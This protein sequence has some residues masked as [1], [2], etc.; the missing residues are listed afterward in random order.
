VNGLVTVRAFD[1]VPVFTR[2]MAEKVNGWT[3][4][5]MAQ[6]CC[7]Q[8]LGMRISSLAACSIFLT[9]LAI[10]LQPDR[11]DAGLVGLIL[12]YANM[13]NSSLQGFLTRL[14]DVEI[15][16]NGVER[17]RYFAQ[18]VVREAPYTAEEPSSGR[19]LEVAPPS[20]PSV[21][22]VRFLDVAAKYRPEL[23]RVL[24]GLTMD[25]AASQKVGVC[26]RT[27][28]G[29]STLM[30]LLF[31]ILE[32]DA[33]SIVIDGV[34]IANLGLSQL[35]CAIAMLPQ[36]PT[37][38]S[39][40]IRQNLDPFEQH[41]DAELTAALEKAQLQQTFGR[42]GQ[43]LDSQVGEGGGS[44]S[45]GQR[46]LLCFARA[47]LRGSKLLVMDECTANVDV[48]TDAV[49]QKMVREVFKDCT[50]FTIAHRLATVIDYD[51]IAVLDSGRLVEFGVPAE[52]LETG[53]HLT[54]LVEQTGPVMAAHLRA[55][56][57]AAQPT[58]SRTVS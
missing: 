43:T 39:G 38:F 45:V 34:N 54:R 21:G 42:Q 35:R 12:T 32:L 36:D 28:S 25:V 27:G 29:K 1:A 41:G 20:W 57:T 26:G 15:R 2:Q 4:S 14:T 33:G 18:T 31:R 17:I 13:V 51:R 3:Q 53:G 22:T 30:L 19:R 46:Q 50:I 11:L 5:E 44:L 47:L 48:E 37:L 6:N 10:T 55:A 40:T 24:Q 52:L 9:S 58:V 49:L 56:A 16:M 23:T 8:W 7:P